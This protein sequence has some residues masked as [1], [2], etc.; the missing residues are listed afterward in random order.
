M[1]NLQITHSRINLIQACLWCIN[2]LALNCW[3]PEEPAEDELDPENADVLDA[4]PLEEDGIELFPDILWAMTCKLL[5]QRKYRR[6]VQR[7]ILVDDGIL[8][9]TEFVSNISRAQLSRLTG[10]SGRRLAR[11]IEHFRV[12]GILSPPHQLLP[13]R[14]LIPPAA[15]ID[16]TRAVESNVR[17][18]AGV[19]N[20]ANCVRF[21]ILAAVKHSS[22]IF[23]LV[24]RLLSLLAV[25]LFLSFGST[26]TAES[27]P[28]GDWFFCNG[29]ATH[30]YEVEGGYAFHMSIICFYPGGF[31]D[32]WSGWGAGPFEGTVCGEGLG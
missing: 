28:D 11:A 21:D 2:Y 14:V 24:K 15:Q 31:F 16:N 32:T 29:C 25:C 10:I 9:G 6:R 7:V 12:D 3:H 1:I 26:P 19:S 5:A 27:T 8:V 13:A 18:S 20:L 22:N 23:L 30:I 4:D 17:V